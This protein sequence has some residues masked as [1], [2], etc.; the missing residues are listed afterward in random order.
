MRRGPARTAIITAI[1]EKGYD[2]IAVKEKL[3]KIYEEEEN[4]L[5]SIMQNL[6][7]MDPGCTTYVKQ[8]LIA[9]FRRGFPPAFDS[10]VPNSKKRD[11][12]TVFN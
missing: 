12:M 9:S 2:W 11:P 6:V 3:T 1:Q 10:S 7:K 4:F 5:D 8:D